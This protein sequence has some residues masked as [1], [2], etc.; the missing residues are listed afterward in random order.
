VIENI[1][2]GIAGAD[3]EHTPAAVPFCAVKVGGVDQLAAETVHARPVRSPRF[4]FASGGDDHVPRV[5]DAARRLNLPAI[6]D[7]IEMMTGCTVP[8][9]EL[10]AACSI[11]W[12]DFIRQLLLKAAGGL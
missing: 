12:S 11:K 3:D 4:P 10:T 6:R 1:N 9:R 2:A 8:R 7:G 5:A